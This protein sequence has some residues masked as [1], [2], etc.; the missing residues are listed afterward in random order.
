MVEIQVFGLHPSVMHI[1]NVVLHAANT[2]LLLAWLRRATG[3]LWPSA[4]VA[5]LFALHPLHVESVA[6]I[7][8]RKDVLSTLFLL[9]AIHA[10]SAH[11]RRPAAWRYAALIG[12]FVLGLLAKPMLVTLPLL[13]LLCDVWPI[14]RLP[15]DQWSGAAWRRWR[16][17]IIEKWPLFVIAAVGAVLVFVTQRAGGAMAFSDLMPL[18]RR[19]ANALVSTVIYVWQTL[20]P[21]NLAV[22]Y[23]YP[24]AIPAWQVAGAIAL[25]LA[26]TGAALGS[27][28]P[29]IVAG[30]AWFL[31]ALAP[32]SG[33]IQ[34]GVQPRADRFTYVP[35]IGLF[36]AVVWGLWEWAS[37][38]RIA[39]RTLAAIAVVVSVACAYGSSRQL[40]YWR[41]SVTLWARAVD[42]TP[43]PG[44]EQAHFE[45]ARQLVEVGRL[46]EAVDHY[47]TAVQLNP[48]WGGAYGLL[49]IAYGKLG[50]EEEAREAYEHGLRLEPDQPEVENNL[51]VI[52]ASRGRMEEAAQHF[53]AAAKLKADFDMARANL[54]LA[55]MRLGRPEDA[56]RAFDAALAIN[57]S[58]AQARQLRDKLRQK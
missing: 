51:G 2:L 56:L 43:G 41:D 48:E 18:S 52:L 9:L 50:R 32:V 6:W 16:E 19:L 26:V 28:R 21:R 8:E 20:V 57:P 33:I 54:G 36:I 15:I 37:A 13:L 29:A 10:Y 58:N 14:G 11:A 49:G 12:S 30:W 42:V 46:P 1:T 3:R 27:R 39:G 47:R 38:R 22:L 24:D 45:L 31:I 34:V 44:G 25:L 4:V 23:P 53:E 40:G 7:T 5:A 55:Y 17:A 35:L